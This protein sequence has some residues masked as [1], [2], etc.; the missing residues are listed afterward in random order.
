MVARGYVVDVQEDFSKIMTEGRADKE[1]QEAD[2][3]SNGQSKS[4][5]DKVK[6]NLSDQ[7]MIEVTLLL[8]S[9]TYVGKEEQNNRKLEITNY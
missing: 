3:V 9:I 5:K 4:P 6:D 2:T 8:S 1:S 7:I